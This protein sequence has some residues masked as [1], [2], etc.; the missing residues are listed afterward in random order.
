MLH[1]SNIR[2]LAFFLRFCHHIYYFPQV[3]SIDESS[4]LLTADHKSKFFCIQY[5]HRVISFSLRVFPPSP[6]LSFFLLPGRSK[7]LSSIRGNY[8][9]CEY[10]IR[11]P[12]SVGGPSRPARPRAHRSVYNRPPGSRKVKSRPFL[13]IWE[14]RKVQ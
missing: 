9:S 5:I 13:D 7:Y 10:F 11:Y 14:V 3:P 2:K 4:L 12:L 6:K 8:P 1:G